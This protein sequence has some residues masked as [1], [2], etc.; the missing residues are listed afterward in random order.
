MSCWRGSGWSFWW[1]PWEIFVSVFLS[2]DSVVLG[3]RCHTTR[4]EKCQEDGTSSSQKQRVKKKKGSTREDHEQIKTMI[5]MEAIL[6]GNHVKG[7]PQSRIIPSSHPKRDPWPL[8]KTT[9]SCGYL[10]DRCL[11]C[12]CNARELGSPSLQRKCLL[13]FTSSIGRAGT[14]GWRGVKSVKSMRGRCVFSSAQVFESTTY[15]RTT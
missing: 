3:L 13:S 15:I 6:D 12:R 10:A 8:S 14:R 4:Q 7:R 5:T 2:V 9:R 11:P 1:Q